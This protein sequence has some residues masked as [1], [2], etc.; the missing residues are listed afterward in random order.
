MEG[1]SS[2]RQN[3]AQKT[4]I[5]GFVARPIRTLLKADKKQDILLQ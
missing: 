1:R 4:E 5:S 3:E 2:T